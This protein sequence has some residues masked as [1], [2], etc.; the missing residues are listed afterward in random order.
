MS[1]FAHLSSPLS[2][3]GE[4]LAAGPPQ[5][6]A[7][8]TEQI[9]EETRLTSEKDGPSSAPYTVSVLDGAICR[10]IVTPHLYF[11]YTFSF[12]HPH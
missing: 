8:S 5:D 1:D 7:V 9:A 2:D 4:A 6:V 11:F 3:S 12:P 10:C